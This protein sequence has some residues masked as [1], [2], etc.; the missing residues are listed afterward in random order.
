MFVFDMH[1]MGQLAFDEGLKSIL[2]HA[3]I[4][5]VRYKTITY[6]TSLLV[7]MKIPKIN[8]SKVSLLFTLL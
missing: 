2:E 8:E 7:G 4:Q 1:K 5:K 3:D 6:L